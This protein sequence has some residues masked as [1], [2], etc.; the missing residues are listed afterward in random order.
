MEY[1]YLGESTLKVSAV[2]LGCRGF[3]RRDLSVDASKAVVKKALDMGINFFD[4]AD[5]Y[6]DGQS[7]E[8]L[9]AALARRP[10]D[11]YILATKGGS[12]RLAPGMET[13]NGDPA[14]LRKSL[15]A[16]LQ[17]LGTDYIDLYQLHNPD[18]AVPLDYTAEAFERFVQEGKVRHVGVSNMDARELAE[19][20]RLVPETV[21]IQL[22][23]SLL[24]RVKV[25]AVFPPG[26]ER[27][28]SLIPWAPLFAGF[29]VDPPPLSQEKRSGFYSMLTEEFVEKALKV[30]A[31]V[32]EI[33]AD[34]WTKPSIVALAYVLNRPEVGTV[35]VGMTSPIHLQENLRALEISISPRDLAQLEKASAAVPPPEMYRIMEVSEVLDGGHLAV[36]P[37]GLKVRVPG[38]VKR[39]DR[40]EVNLWDGR[41]KEE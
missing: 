26:H 24:D 37:M 19:W 11:S 2:S 4:T 15:D 6:G 25:D 21:S 39:G 36:L 32:R 8:Y 20:M 7:E 17:R 10:R 5:V 3:G 40:I 33:A 41:L 27:V 23:C 12:Q 28:V 29:L 14:Y 1:R 18:P 38:G 34:Y 35:P 31:L 16:S 9:A 13:Q 30:C 22:S